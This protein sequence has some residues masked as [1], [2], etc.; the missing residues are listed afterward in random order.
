MKRLMLAAVA[1]LSFAVPASAATVITADRYLDVET[2]RYVQNPAIFV[3]DTG[4]ITSIADARTVKWGA[5]V[6]H[7]D[8]G[9]RTL[10]PGLIDMHTHLGPA[11]IGGY[12]FLE[13]TGS[14]WPVVA[15][16]TARDM[17]NGGFTTMRVVGS[18]EWAG[19]SMNKA[20]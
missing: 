10:L 7:I 5:D 6:K 20:I 18:G 11:D 3:D 19:V 1:A 12:R 16:S 4:H 2:G 17:L 8:L 14:F 13:Y 15:T 9:N